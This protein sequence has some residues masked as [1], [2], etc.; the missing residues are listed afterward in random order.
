MKLLSSTTLFIRSHAPRL[1]G[2]RPSSAVHLFGHLA[3]FWRWRARPVGLERSF[4]D[5]KRKREEENEDKRE[6]ERERGGGR[7]RG[8]GGGRWKGKCRLRREEKRKGRRKRREE[9]EDVC[10]MENE[11]QCTVPF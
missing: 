2:R 3:T 1:P 5:P 6:R 9:R 11:Q 10:S 4:R 8:R 7:K